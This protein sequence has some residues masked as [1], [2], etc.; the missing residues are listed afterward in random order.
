ML[1]MLQSR[2][3]PPLGKYQSEGRRRCHGGTLNWPSP[4]CQLCHHTCWPGSALSPRPG[5]VPELTT[6]CQPVMVINKQGYWDI[7][8]YLFCRYLAIIWDIKCFKHYSEESFSFELVVYIQCHD[9]FISW[10]SSWHHEHSLGRPLGNTAPELSCSGWTKTKV[11]AVHWLPLLHC[12]VTGQVLPLHCHTL[13]LQAAA[14]EAWL[15][16]FLY[17]NILHDNWLLYYAKI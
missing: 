12:L 10:W 4:L 13:P 8:A 11:T 9:D 3:T 5:A 1:R 17:Q 7:I 15:E 16:M 14:T 2:Q 6:L